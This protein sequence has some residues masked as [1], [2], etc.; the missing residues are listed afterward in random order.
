M[1]IVLRLKEAEVFVEIWRRHYNAV[2][3]HSAL[4]YLS[5]ASYARALDHPLCAKLQVSDPGRG[6]GTTSVTISVFKT[7]L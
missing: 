1:R 7:G 4:G 6:E 3:S 5:P 2:R